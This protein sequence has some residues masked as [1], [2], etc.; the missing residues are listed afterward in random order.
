[1]AKA[2]EEALLA[3]SREASSYFERFDKSLLP[4]AAVHLGVDWLLSEGGQHGRDPP[5]GLIDCKLQTN[6]SGGFTLLFPRKDDHTR[7]RQLH[8]KEL[9]QV[10]RELI[11][12]IYVFNQ[13]PSVSLEPNHDCTTTCFIPSAYN[14]TVIGETLLSVDYYIK[15]LL[16]GSTVPQKD[17]RGKLLSEWKKIPQGSL[18]KKFRED[19]M[20]SMQ[21]DEELG[22]DVYV[23]HKTPFI[24]Y[25]PKCI[26]KE[27]TYRQLTPRLTT[28]EEFTQ[29]ED[30]MSRDTFHQYLDQVSIGL[31]FYQKRISQKHHIFMMEPSNEVVTSVL[32]TQ[33]KINPSLQNRLNR[34]LQKQ[35][36]FIS[37]KLRKKTDIAHDV[38]LLEFV[39]FMIYFLVTL[40]KNNWII[41]VSNLLPSRSKES[42]HTERE[43]P[44]IFPTQSSR[45]SPYLS[46]NSYTGM[47]G[48][49]SFLQSQLS[50][51]SV[52]I[53]ASE[54]TSII[55]SL[56][57]IVI[58]GGGKS[59]V[60][61]FTQSTSRLNIERELPLCEIGGKMFYVIQFNVEPYFSRLPRWVHAM[62]AELKTQCAKLPP[63]NDARIQ[64]MLRKPLGPRKAASLKTVNVTL[65]ASIEK[66]CLPA[67]GALL[68][69]CTKTRLRKPDDKGMTMLHYAAVNGKTDIISALILAGS[70]IDCCL[71]PD[72][73]QE[74][75]T[76]AIHLA[77]QSGRVSAVCSL[78]RYGA[79]VCARD[80]DGWAPIHFAAFNNSQ[81]VIR[82]IVTLNSQLKDMETENKAR[83]TPILLAAENGCFDSFKCLVEMGADLTV[84]NSGGCNIVHLVTLKYH[85]RI[86]KY[87]IE[88]NDERVDVWKVLSEMLKSDAPFPETA[89]RS[90]DPLTQWK[91]EKSDLFLKYGIIDSLVHLIMGDEKMQL[92]AS[93]VL[94]NLSNIE[95]IKN[96]LIR[97][98]AVSHLVNLLTSSNDRIQAYTCLI[99]SDLGVLPDNQISIASSGAI[100]YLTKLLKSEIDD[101]QLFS[102]AC[103]GILAYENPK[104][105]KL[106]SEAAAI[107]ILVSLLKSNLS[108]L[109][110]CAA[111]ALEAV[112]DGNR[113]NQL[114]ALGENIIPP[115]LV[116][117]RSKEIPVHISAAKVIEALATDCEESQ[118]EL[119]T[120]SVCINL[121]K[122][123]LRMISPKVKVS[124]GCALWAIAGHLISNKRL[125]ATHMGLE[126]LVDLLSLHNEKLDFVCAEALGAL[127]SEL[128]DNQHQIIHVGGVKPLVEV[129][130]IP[131]SQRVCLSVI[132]TL[133]GLCMKSALV[134]NHEV[135]TAIALSRGIVILSSLVSDSQADEIVRVEAACTLAKLILSNQDNDKILAKHTNFSFLSIFKFF[136]SS[137]AIVRLL[138]GYCL[139]IIA[140][141]NPRKVEKMRSF[142]TLNVSNFTFF[143]ESDNQFYQTHAAFQIVVLSKLL[144]GI[145]DADAIVKGIKLLIKLL[146][147]HVEQTKV[148]SAEFIASLSRTTNGVPGALVMAGVLDPLMQNL[149]SGNNPVI[150]SASV[151]LG[152]LTF[153]YMA[154]RLIIGMFRDCPEMFDIF[155]QYFPHIVYSQKFLENWNHITR[156]GIPSLR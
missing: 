39:S 145:R 144:T 25:P 43:F 66:G 54:L 125:I 52:D 21:E 10:V 120:D 50:P 91:P 29:Q 127:A 15:S 113:S 11:E 140:F 100:P 3:A 116:L 8:L 1:M 107:P 23:E 40:K 75:R 124:V 148:M 112:I 37:E 137:D 32:A 17:K 111:S 142:G 80:D 139:S 154:S 146:S 93:Q 35:R 84:S 7:I 59:S 58:I 60:T 129:L 56:A 86:L 33:Q 103:L 16:H 151:A 130:T 57:S 88:I 67:V 128:G 78:L 150:E 117:L 36:T 97:S 106:I 152:Y 83:S 115:L 51:K 98:D 48:A 62:S 28:G 101:V 135:Q 79:D 131:T 20:I 42:T 76:Q 85:I 82:H 6:E 132:H 5:G 141:N 49:I 156:I 34:Y 102:C 71:S 68:R 94:A 41:D 149:C 95:G 108:C 96:A 45:W 77:V 153:N 4:H 14:N 110:S 136:T 30:Y 27:I 53:S 22:E 9:H 119:L 134:P 13:I 89:V 72:G 123:L 19:G 74:S 121:L 31:V 143:L 155:K 81:F 118:R 2:M 47:H 44:P 133:A 12:G 126:L 138:A 69:R 109:Q 63:L 92:L 73:E 24:R 64:D 38:D 105:Q 55:K 18:K 65:Q 46:E 87:L 114:F 90:L 26:N 61:S 70:V 99:L 104:N 122:R 147:S